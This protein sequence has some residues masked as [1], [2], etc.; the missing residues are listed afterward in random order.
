MV[1]PQIDRSNCNNFKTK[2]NTPGPGV[3]A[4]WYRAGLEPRDLEKVL[5]SKFKPTVVQVTVLLALCHGAWDGSTN[6]LSGRSGL[7]CGSVQVTILLAL[8]DSAWLWGFQYHVVLG[9]LLL[10]F[11]NADNYHHLISLEPVLGP[12]T[13]RHLQRK[14]SESKFLMAWTSI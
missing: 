7:G 13:T 5:D 2:A 14:F 6:S 9:D 10:C 4:Q 8:W 12:L 11:Q 1:V 3:M